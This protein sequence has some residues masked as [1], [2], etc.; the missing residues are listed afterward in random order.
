M[1]PLSYILSS[2]LLLI[3]SAALLRLLYILPAINRI[4]PPPRRRGTP[5]HLLIV[6]GSG[7]HTAEML[8]LLSN[9]EFSPSVYTHRSYV[10][11]SGDGFSAGRAEEFEQNFMAEKVTGKI[12]YTIHTVPRAREIHQSLLSTPFTCLHCLYA[13]FCLILFHPKGYP[14][15]IL[16]NGPATSLI[17]VLASIILRYFAFVP[18]FSPILS[19]DKPQ[20]NMRTIYIESW[21]RVKKPSLTGRLIVWCGLCNRVLVQWKGLEE[22]G[23]GEYRG[24]LVT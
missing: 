11:G 20:G 13:C 24:V 22:R 18:F 15:L 9:H 14:D 16:I 5:T 19:H 17:V 8:S 2:L 6:L 1:T 23:W 12:G 21:A 10:V 4:R 3:L 7:G